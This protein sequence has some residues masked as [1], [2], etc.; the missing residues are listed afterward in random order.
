MH[1][2]GE[3][4][5]DWLP[6]GDESR[7]SLRNEMGIDRWYHAMRKLLGIDPDGICEAVCSCGQTHFTSYQILLLSIK[8]LAPSL[9]VGYWRWEKSSLSVHFVNPAEN[10]EFSG[11]WWRNPD[12]YIRTYMFNTS[13]FYWSQIVS[14]RIILKLLILKVYSQYNIVLASWK[15][16]LP[17]PSRN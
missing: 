7:R 10:R 16:F 15:F 3:R 11:L 17:L 5:Q 2:I 9:E 8:D 14:Q 12:T 13:L 1:I 4:S 6:A